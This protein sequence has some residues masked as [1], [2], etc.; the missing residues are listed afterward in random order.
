MY[1]RPRT[2]HL[3]DKYGAA[4]GHLVTAA[5]L[6]LNLE[7]RLQDLKKAER[8]RREYGLF[9]RRRVQIAVGRAEASDLQ[10][11]WE[12]VRNLDYL[13]NGDGRRFGGWR[14]GLHGF[15]EVP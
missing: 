6:V 3:P 4:Y 7:G 1:K 10:Q 11:L 12:V 9:G 15:G 5:T 2:H 14:I 8:R 13:K